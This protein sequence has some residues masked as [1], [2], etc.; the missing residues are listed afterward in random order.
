M[1][2]LFNIGGGEIILVLATVLILFGADNLPGSRRRIFRVWEKADDEAH[3]A[4]RSVGGILGSG[5]AQPL[6]PDNQVA[7]LYDPAAFQDEPKLRRTQKSLWRFFKS[8]LHRVIRFL[9][10]LWTRTA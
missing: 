2:A 1:L 5:A 8:L 3:E 7:E 9:A 6:T 4:G 10:S